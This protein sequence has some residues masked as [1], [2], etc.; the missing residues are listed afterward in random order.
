MPVLNLPLLEQNTDFHRLREQIY[1]EKKRRMNWREPPQ[2]MRFTRTDND[3]G[4]TAAAAILCV[5]LCP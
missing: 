3:D 2:K 4:R 5:N 1:T